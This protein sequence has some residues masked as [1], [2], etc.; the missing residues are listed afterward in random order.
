MT[1]YDLMYTDFTMSLSSSSIRE[2]RM[3][4]SP[5]KL[6]DGCWFMMATA[7]QVNGREESPMV[8]NTEVD[9][10][11]GW[12]HQMETFSALLALC[13]GN[14]LVT[15]EIPAQRPVTLSFDF[16][17]DQHLNKRLS[18]QSWDWWLETQSRSL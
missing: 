12:R 1:N 18:K 14:S 13:A 8:H 16:F 3:C 2:N 10:L 15:G 7:G 5:G 17:F 6:N 4:K 9:T 11:P